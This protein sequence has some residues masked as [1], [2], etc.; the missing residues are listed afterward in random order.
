[1]LDVARNI[2]HQGKQLTAGIWKKEMGVLLQGKTF[3][4]I[5]LGTIG[6]ALVKLVEG[7]NFKILAYDLYHDKAFQIENNITYCDLDML[8]NKSDIISIHLNLT[9]KTFDLI[10][11][12]RIALMKSEAIL[13][14]ASRGEIIDEKALYNALKNEQILGAGLDVFKEEP[15]N[16]PLTELENVVVTPHIGSYA[17]EI[18]IKM[19]IEA[20]ENVVKGLQNE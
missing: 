18:R 9:D 14:N 4:I 8:L 17:K 16:G 13:I 2:S 19:E 6:K 1:M 20:A 15:Y 7:F 3:G 11:E 12:K 5:G 10:N